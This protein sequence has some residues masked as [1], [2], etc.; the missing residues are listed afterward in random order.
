VADGTC[1][2][3]HRPRPS[4]DDPKFISPV[5]DVRAGMFYVSLTMAALFWLGARL[6]LAFVGAT[7]RSAFGQLLGV[8]PAWLAAYVLPRWDPLGVV[9]WYMD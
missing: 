6:L 4:L 2:L 8:P 3:G 7:R 5:V 1:A 9:Y